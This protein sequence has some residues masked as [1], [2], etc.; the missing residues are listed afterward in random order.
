MMSASWNFAESQSSHSKAMCDLR[1]THKH[2][3]KKEPLA[4]EDIVKAVIWFLKTD[5]K[6]II[7]NWL[8]CIHYQKIARILVASMLVSHWC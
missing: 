7:G 4:D 5:V 6:T 3:N 2:T 1:K 8:L